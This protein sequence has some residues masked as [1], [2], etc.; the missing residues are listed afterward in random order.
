MYKHGLVWTQLRGHV[1]IQ[2]LIHAHMQGINNILEYVARSAPEQ[3]QQ[4]LFGEYT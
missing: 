2:A 3:V 1:L 4:Q